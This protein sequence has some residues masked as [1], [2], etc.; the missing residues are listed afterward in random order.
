[1]LGYFRQ[2]LNIRSANI[3]ILRDTRRPGISRRGEEFFDFRT[4]GDFPNE[5]M[6]PGATTNNEDFQ[7]EPPPVFY[8]SVIIRLDLII[9]TPPICL[10]SRSRIGYGTS[11]AG[12]TLRCQFATLRSR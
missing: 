2:R 7:F 4:L 6:F 12:M 5:G 3:D 1:L 8:F 11:F 10:D 9:Q